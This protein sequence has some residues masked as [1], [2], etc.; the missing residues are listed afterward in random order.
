MLLTN[1]AYGNIKANV[2]LFEVGSKMGKSTRWQV[3]II[4]QYSAM[5]YVHAER[6]SISQY[7][8]N[9]ENISQ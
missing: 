4:I 7:W 1:C 3:F 5:H 8:D 2:N 9:D 6:H